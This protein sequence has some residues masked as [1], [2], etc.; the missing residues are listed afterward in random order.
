M[1]P[2]MRREQH[3]DALWTVKTPE[4]GRIQLV[5]ITPGSRTVGSEDLRVP[6]PLADIAETS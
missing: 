3:E 6:D 4:L 5:F 1:E 2:K